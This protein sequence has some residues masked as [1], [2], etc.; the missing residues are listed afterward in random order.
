ML[1][2]VLECAHW[3]GPASD[4]SEATFNGIGGTHGPTLNFGF[5]AKAAQ[6]FVEIV[7]QASDGSRILVL[8]T[9]C[10]TTRGRAG[11]GAVG[12]IQ[13]LVQSPFDLGR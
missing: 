1:V 2:F 9:L 6:Q 8:E 5:I 13:D 10:K 7:A 3:P 12:G 4:C 11:C